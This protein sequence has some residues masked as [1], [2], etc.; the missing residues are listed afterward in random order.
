MKRPFQ[1]AVLVVGLMV[2]AVAMPDHVDAKSSGGGG[3]MSMGGGGKGKSSSNNKSN[4]TSVPRSTQ[5][6]ESPEIVAARTTLADAKD[7]LDGIVAK[8]YEP[9]SKSPAY[10][11]AETAFSTT[12]ANVKTAQAALLAKLADSDDYKQAIKDRDDAKAAMQ[13]SGGD[14][15]DSGATT[16]FAENEAK[17][18]DAKAKVAKFEL[19]ASATDPATKAAQAKYDDAKK[20][21]DAQT[22]QFQDSIKADPDWQAAKKAYDEADANLQSL[23]AAKKK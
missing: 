10:Q 13:T 16:S 6:A 20:A 8:L 4:N 18:L 3:K 1:L 11:D 7:K 15:G 12:T 23:L 17:Y 21:V 5:P 22:A 19:D 2:L 14:S 9:F